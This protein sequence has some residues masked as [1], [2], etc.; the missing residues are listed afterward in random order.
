MYSFRDISISK[1]SLAGRQAAHTQVCPLF[2]KELRS[3]LRAPLVITVLVSI[4][5]G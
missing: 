1:A 4:L 2:E 5:V 3:A